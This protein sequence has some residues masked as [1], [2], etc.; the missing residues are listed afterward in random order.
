MPL[1]AHWLCEVLSVVLL[2]DS[3]PGLFTAECVNT[4]TPI[5]ID[6]WMNAQ[7]F[8][9]LLCEAPFALDST[10]KLIWDQ[11]VSLIVTLLTSVAKVMDL[12][13]S[14]SMGHSRP[15][16][17][18][19]SAVNSYVLYYILAHDA[20]WTTYLRYWKQGTVNWDT[21]TNQDMYSWSL[22]RCETKRVEAHFGKMR[23]LQSKLG[24]NS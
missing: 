23:F 11:D 8:A 14:F 15:L 19:F 17:S 18:L 5:Y 20:I 16:F 13:F 6:G 4:R 22:M 2:R 12:M 10:W 3:N 24:F 1:I 9:C 21:T 7:S